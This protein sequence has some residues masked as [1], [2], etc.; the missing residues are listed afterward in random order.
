MTAAEMAIRA[1]APDPG[2]LAWGGR[3]CSTTE[4]LSNTERARPHGMR[5][6]PYGGWHLPFGAKFADTQYRGRSSPQA[7]DVC[8]SAVAGDQVKS[9]PGG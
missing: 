7:A 8:N 5:I 9:T 6:R 2:C 1:Q 3:R 4:P